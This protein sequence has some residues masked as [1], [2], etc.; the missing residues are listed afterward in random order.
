MR[1]GSIT[2]VSNAPTAL[3]CVLEDNPYLV[4]LSGA[5]DPSVVFDEIESTYYFANNLS[6][7][8]WHAPSD[9]LLGGHFSKLGHYRFPVELD[10][11]SQ[12]PSEDQ[13]GRYTRL[14]HIPGTSLVIHGNTHVAP[15]AGEVHIGSIHKNTGVIDGTQPASFS[16]GFNGTCNLFSNSATRFFCFDGA[17][18]RVYDTAVGSSALTYVESIALSQPLVEPCGNLCYGGTFAW[19]G[20]YFYFAYDGKSAAD[21]R[22]SVYDASGVFVATYE[23]AGAGA[24]DSAYFDWSA[25][26]YATHDGYGGRSGGDV[27]SWGVEG[28]DS[29]CYGPKSPDHE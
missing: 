14:I 9:Q 13:T 5:P 27:Y 25:G 17:A 18:I 11:Y 2:A 3:G 23:A 21:R 15:T 19:D 26:R 28:D 1:C 6:N 7:M 22:Y 29:Q 12:F 8:I 10:G 16:D 4:C 20:L 24:I